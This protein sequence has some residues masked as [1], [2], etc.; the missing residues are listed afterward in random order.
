MKY[1][2]YTLLFLLFAGCGKP[3][4]YYD[5]NLDQENVLVRKLNNNHQYPNPPSVY[6]VTDQETGNYFFVVEGYQSIS[7]TDIVENSK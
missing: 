4:T 3:K 7:C 5:C 2:L 6:R 1:T